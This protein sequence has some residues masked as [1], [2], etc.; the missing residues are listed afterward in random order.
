MDA[1]QMTTEDVAALPVSGQPPENDEVRQWVRECARLCQPAAL[2]WCDGSR[3]EKA[4]LLQQAAA[5][6]VLIPLNPQAL[7]DCY[8]HRSHPNDTARTEHCTFICT[9]TRELAGPTNN[10]MAPE[11]AYRILRGCFADSMRGRTMYV[12]PF[13]MGHAGSP[14]AKVGVELTDSLYVA[15]SMGLMTRMGRP[16]MDA[17]GRGA[18]FTRCLHSVGECDPQRRY[19]CH[20]PQDNT[21]WGYGSGYGGNA[22]LG[23]KCLSLRIGSYLGWQEGWL[24]EHM[25]IAAVSE[26]G[27]E[28]TY[29]TGAFPSA[30]GK[31]NLAM[32]APP[33]PF[34]ARGW[35]V[36]TL[37]DDIAWMY[38]GKEG[39]LRALN[40]E[41]GYFGVVPGTNRATNPNAVAIMSRGAIYTNV[42]LLPDGTVWWEGKDGLVPDHGLDWTGQPWTP[43]S[44]RKAAH[45]NSRFTA[46]LTHNPALSP[47]AEDPRGVPISA[48]IFGS[49]RSKTVPLIVESFDWVHGVYLGAM[50]GSETTAAATGQVGMVRRDPMAMLPF[51]GYNM[52][53][54]F[55]H[56]L[57]FQTRLAKP[58]RIFYVNWFRTDDQGKVLWPG[59]GE[60]LRILKWIVDRCRERVGAIKTPLGW[61]PRPEDVAL[62]GLDRERFL[63]AQA[64]DTQAWKQELLAQEELFVRLGQDMPKELVAER[65][66]LLNRL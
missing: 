65:E 33:E 27:G 6:G 34:R 3:T 11:E 12:V 26:P 62:E 60:N 10:W 25:L 15:L 61:M 5:Q 24:A 28:T 7:P 44:G 43:S 47:K 21:V 45:P 17:L 18:Q 9:L 52:G 14:L 19:I 53:A 30:C 66:R 39:E 35:K 49:R 63:Q 31:T 40:P 29:V 51:C 48:I 64:I 37:G 4:A 58:P 20:F 23:K 2:H 42:A 8:L 46:P 36:E 32:L 1:T 41:A 13:L 54:Y 56:W 57:S 55:T 22:L 38:I 59:F 16:A 50:M